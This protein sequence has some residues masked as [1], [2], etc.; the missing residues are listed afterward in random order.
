VVKRLTEALGGKVTYE[1]ELGKGTKFI[2]R[3]PPPQRDKR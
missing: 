1:S 2:V 3:L